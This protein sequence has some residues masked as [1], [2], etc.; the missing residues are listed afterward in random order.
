[1]VCGHVKEPPVPGSL[2]CSGLCLVHEMAGV[3]MTDVSQFCGWH[4]GLHSVT[5][6][7]GGRLVLF[8]GAPKSGPMLGDLWSLDLASSAWEELDPDGQARLLP[9]CSDVT[10][11]MLIACWQ[12]LPAL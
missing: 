3:L 1:M 12:S 5:A 9:F 11:W 10:P 2:R 7:A 4:S 6:T 8:A